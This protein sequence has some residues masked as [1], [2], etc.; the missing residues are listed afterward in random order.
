MSPKN[1][2]SIDKGELTNCKIVDT[3]WFSP[4]FASPIW[5]NKHIQVEWQWVKSWPVGCN[6]SNHVFAPKIANKLK[7]GE[8]KK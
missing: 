3:H 4:L 6:I 1:I 7:N 5:L 2:N 8:L